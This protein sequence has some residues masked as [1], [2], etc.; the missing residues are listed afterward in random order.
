VVLMAMRPAGVL[1]PLP[2]VV[3]RTGHAP[4]RQGEPCSGLWVVESGVFRAEVIDRE[5]RSF[6]VDLLGSGDVLG[7][8]D[9]GP[10]PWTA[11]ALRPSRLHSVAPAAAAALLAD[12]ARRA[13]TV[14]GEL[15]WLGVTD[16]IERRLRDLAE[17]HGRPVAGGQLIPVRLTQDDVAAMVGATRESANRA[18]RTL[19]ARGL[20]DVQG[21]GRYVVRAQ[22]RLAPA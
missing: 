19:V 5:G 2:L 21:R 14:A 4:V 22:L 8:P 9:A 18:V 13:V 6:V 15:A 3:V 20:L 11:T 12:R 1:E 16:R 17:R 7:E 10:A